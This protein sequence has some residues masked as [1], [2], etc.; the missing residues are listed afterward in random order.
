M[1]TDDIFSGNFLPLI[2]I[3]FSFCVLFSFTVCITDDIFIW[4][5]TYSFQKTQHRK[6]VFGRWHFG[7]HLP[8]ATRE[9]HIHLVQGNRLPRKSNLNADE[10]SLQWDWERRSFVF[11]VLCSSFLY[12]VLYCLTWVNLLELFLMTGVM[13]AH[14]S[15]MFAGLITFQK[16]LEHESLVH[17]ERSGLC[18]II[19]PSVLSP[20]R[21]IVDT[22]RW[23]DMD[24]LT[25]HFVKTPAG[26]WK[27]L[28]T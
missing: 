9:G 17:S 13:G 21:S 18:G 16:H 1:S 22:W 26:S 12:G 28:I 27:L 14:L 15:E 25:S 24:G 3:F 23:T 7:K 8:V 11:L 5:M 2:W 19:H 4:S 10:W 20:Q 6:A